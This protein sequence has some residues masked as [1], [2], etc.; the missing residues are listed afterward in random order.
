MTQRLPSKIPH[1][2]NETDSKTFLRNKSSRSSEIKLVY[3]SYKKR[4]SY[5]HLGRVYH[6]AIKMVNYT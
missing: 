6:S 3:I 4:L 2:N 1:W 5:E